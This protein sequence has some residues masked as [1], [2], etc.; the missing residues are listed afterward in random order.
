VSMRVRGPGFRDVLGIG[1]FRALW[2]AELLSILGDQLARVAL[3]LLV[4]ERTASAALSALTYALTLAPA[5]L[6][7]VLLS[8]LADRYPRR[9]V[10][11]VTDLLRAGLAGAM[12]IP[13]LPL[14]AMWALVAVLSMSSA[15]FKAAQQALLPQ[16]LSS[17]SYL[18]GLSLRQVTIQ[19]TQLGGYASGG[20][21]LV[22]LE[23]HVALAAN[24]ATFLAS[25]ALITTG[26]RAR[27]RPTADHRQARRA[28]LPAGNHGPLLP[29]VTL[30]CLVGLF[31]VPTGVAAPY[32]AGIGVGAL[33]VGL[34]MAAD[35]MGSVIGAWLLPRTG[36]RPT[37]RS[38]VT[39]AAAS[40][41]PLLG[42][43]MGPGLGVSIALC[44]ASGALSSAYLILAQAAVVDLVPDHRRGRVMGQIAAS[45]YS[46]QG[47]TIFA[48]G[49][50]AEAVGPF[51][52][53]AGAG[54]LGTVLVLCVGAWWRRVAR[55]RR[56]LDTGS[57]HDSGGGTG[58][59]PVLLHDRPLLP[60][61]RAELVS[62]EEADVSPVL[63]HGGHLLS[64]ARGSA[65]QT[66]ESPVLL[67]DEHLLPGHQAP[68]ERATDSPVLLHDQHLLSCRQAPRV[69]EQTAESPVLL[70]HGHLLP[71]HQAP[72]ERATDSPVLLHDQHLLPQRQ[73]T[74]QTVESPVLLHGQHLLSCRQAPRVSEQTADS[75]A[76]LHDEH[77]LPRHQAPA[78]RTT[79][80]PV[81]LHD[82][83]LLP[84]QQPTEQTVESPVLLHDE[85][86]LP[87][88]QAPAERTRDSPVLLHDQHL[89]PH[90]QAPAERTRDS[91]VLLHDGHLLPQPRSEPVCDEG[92]SGS[93]VLLHDRHLLPHQE[94]RPHQRR[95]TAARRQLG[96]GIVVGTQASQ[97][98]R[99]LYLA[100]PARMIARGMACG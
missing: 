67:H 17:E 45:L 65:E 26:V 64:R 46:A 18:T 53:V 40:G 89:L 71:G 2:G 83:H 10:L 68:A 29:L 61:Q 76:L 94:P 32:G 63:L 92:A 79:D 11:I 69:S 36:I 7:G 4:Y 100:P 95:D 31:V 6:G 59:S 15:P 38:I 19:A 66:A 22:V 91:P 62:D 78:E 87:G 33:G 55:S 39:L 24:A 37:R 12:A 51:R 74:E 27:P 72:A 34:I 90:Q 48:G 9:R 93:P 81:L 99:R 56:D 13:S 84:Q 28:D 96:Q 77:L 14:P 44:A 23:P 86:L 43:A 25:A 16:V 35:P 49:L 97:L 21:L 1:E 20:F 41:I 3:A 8:G 57:E 60:G 80:S 54:L 75:P 50:A 5:V 52:A 82:Q 70:H 42:C 58:D 98:W 85:H 73:P 47:L 30:V 88:Q